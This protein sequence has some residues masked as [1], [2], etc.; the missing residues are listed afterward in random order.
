[1]GN[2]DELICAAAGKRHGAADS[3]TSIDKHQC[4]STF[5]IL[6][7]SLFIFVRTF[8]VFPIMKGFLSAVSSRRWKSS[9]GAAGLLC[10]LLG[11]C[12][13]AAV[14]GYKPVIIVHGLFDSSGDFQ[15]LQR[16][17]SEVS[18]RNID[19]SNNKLSY[20]CRMNSQ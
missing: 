4:F 17:I 2:T 15:N 9:S 3:S 20:C 6:L 14:V 13:W 11:A 5:S 12:L 1:M 19:G 8:F 7:Y 18:D 10:P 16:F